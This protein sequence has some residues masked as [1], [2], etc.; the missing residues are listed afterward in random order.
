MKSMCSLQLRVCGWTAYAGEKRGD[1]GAS[2]GWGDSDTNLSKGN[3]D[4]RVPPNAGGKGW[5]WSQEGLLKVWRRTTLFPTSGCWSN[6]SPQS[7]EETAS[8]QHGAAQPEQLLVWNR[9]AQQS[10]D[11]TQW[12][13]CRPTVHKASV[14]YPHKLCMIAHTWNPSTGRWTHNIR[15]SILSSITRLVQD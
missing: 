7:L 11:V 6:T 3:L 9:W 10:K 14:W 5:G 15:R 2:R 12:V 4:H 13:E 1:T 8:S